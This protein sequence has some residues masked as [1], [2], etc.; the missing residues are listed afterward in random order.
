MK[1]F[2]IKSM[3]CYIPKNWCI[4][5]E[6]SISIYDNNGYGALTISILTTFE[7]QATFENTIT[8]IASNFIKSNSITLQS[9]LIFNRDNKNKLVLYGN[10]KENDDWH[11]KM[12]F[13]GKYPKIIVATYHYK[14]ENKKE[15]KKVEKIIKSIKINT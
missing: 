4:D 8:S 11:E 9:P 15:I 3:K 1:K 5:E 12:W 2:C 13:L 7:S 6:D 14:I 10:Y